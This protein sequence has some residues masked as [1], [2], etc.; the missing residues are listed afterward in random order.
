MK[1]EGIRLHQHRLLESLA[2][3]GSDLPLLLWA[4][5]D[6]RRTV[7]YVNALLP[8]ALREA[9]ASRARQHNFPNIEALLG[10]LHADGIQTEVG[11]YQTYVCPRHYAE[12]DTSAV[13]CYPREHPKIQAFGFSGLADEVYAAE[14]DGA[15]CA[16]C[17][18]VRQNHECAEAW[19]FTA[20]EHR[21]RGLGQW[22]V[23]AWAKRVLRSGRVPFYSH[24]M[25][26]VASASLARKLRLMP[27][28][29]EIGITRKA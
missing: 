23:T 12:M 1:L 19:V 25:E 13:T 8:D 3:S 16:A 4:R 15:I 28:F 14:R 20:P 29:E 21:H 27:V 18:S 10:P 9:L 24:R 22:V 5:T 7:A 2:P 6:D 26:N 17:V 11:H